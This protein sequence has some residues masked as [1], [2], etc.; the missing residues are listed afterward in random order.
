M[1][2]LKRYI[3]FLL[4]LCSAIGY[5]QTPTLIASGTYKANGSGASGIPTVTINIPAGKNRLMI[6]S[7]FSERIH[8]PYNSNFVTHSDGDTNGDSSHNI[9]VN[10]ISAQWISGPWTDDTVT[11]SKSTTIFSTQNTVRYISDAM[12]MPSGVATITFPGI[13]LPENS[14]DEM[15]VQIAIFENAKPNPTFLK[16]DNARNFNTDTDFLTLSGTTPT[17]P[18][19]NSINNLVFFGTGGISQQNNVLFSS[20]WTTIQTDVMN[21][22][23][24]T[25]S[26]LS[27]M[28]PNEHDGIGYTTAYRTISSGDPSFTL[29]RSATNLSTETA[30]ANLISILPFARPSVS[31]TVY[32]DNNGMTGGIDNGGTGGGTWNIANALYVNAVDT[33]GNVVATALVNTSGVFTF[34]SGGNLIEGDVVKFQLS[35]TQGTVGQPAP[36]KELPAGWAIVGESTTGGSSDGTPNGEFTLTIGTA[37]SPNSTT[38]RFGVVTACNAGASAP[39]VR[40]TITNTCP[41]ITVNLNT[42]QTGTIPAG[43]SLVW[44]TNSNHTGSA[45]SGTQITQAGAGTYYAFYYDSV[46]SCYSPV[47]NAVTVLINTTD[48]DGDGVFDACDLDNDNDGILDTDE[49]FCLSTPLLI[50]SKRFS[51]TGSGTTGRPN[52]TFSA[53]TTG[54]GKRLM[55]LTLTIE[56]DHTPTPYGDNWESTLPATNN[57]TNAPVVKFGSNNMFPSSYNTSLKSSP[58]INHSD[59]TISVTQYVYTLWD[60]QISAGLNSIDLSNFQ[61]PKN[62]GD[63]WHAEILV[64]DN[65]NNYEYIGTK[66]S[67]LAKNDLSISGNMLANSQPAGTIEQNNALL[68]FG[69]TS[70]QSG[71]SINSGWNAITTNS[72]ANTNGTYATDPNT[73]SDLLENDGI[74]V[75]T[76]TKTGVTGNQTATFS[77]N[78]SMSTAIMYR[79]IPFPCNLRDTDGDGIPD[80]LDLDS[81]AD[82]CPDAKEGAGNFN[83]TATASG[84][85]STQTPN[86]NFGTTVDANGVPTAVGASG[87]ALGQSI[88]ASKNDCLDTDG[89]GYP[90][91]QDLDDDNDGILD[92]VENGLNTTIDKIF[93][94]NNNATLIASPSTGPAH[95]YRL[96][97]VGSQ[98]GQI[99]SYG[100]VD[101]TK[102]FSLPMK[103]L[104]SNADG[105][106]IV[107]HNSP[108]A[109][110]ASGTNGQGL[111]ARGIANGIALE[112][113]TFQNGCDNDTNNG[114]NC[115]PDYDHGSIRTTAGW[116]G[117]GKLA[118]DTKLGDGEVH[119]EPWHNVVINWNASTRNLSYTFDGVAV[120]N[121][122]FPTTG[123]NAIETILGGNSAYFG[124]T[125]STGGAGSTNSVGFDDLCALP[126]TLD[127]DNDG[128]S[129]HLDLDSDGD[130][131]A[132]A[133]EGAGNFTASQLTSASGTL[134]S[135]TPNQNFGTTVD[136]NGVPTVVGASGQALGQSQDKTKNDCIDSDGD[137]YPDWVDLDDD[138]DG[139][140]DTDECVL[141]N[142]VTNGNFDTDFT[143]ASDWSN[144]AGWTYNATGK[145]VENTSTFYGGSFGNFTQL[146]SNLP[147]TTIPLTF[148]LGAKDGGGS[149]TG[150][151]EV[152]LGGTLYATVNNSTAT[153][154]NITLTLSNGATSNFTPFTATSTSTYTN[155]TFTINIPYTGP[156]SAALN[157][158]MGANQTDDWSLDNIS[159]NTCDTDA[160]GIPNNLDLDSDNDGCLDA[161]EGG[162]NFTASQLTTASGTIATQT[163]NQNFGIVVDAN[164]VPTIVGATGQTVGQSL[165]ATKNDCLDSDND[166]YPNW[167][168]LDDD[169]D[170]ILDTDECPNVPIISNGTF[171]SPVT[172]WTLGTGW[173]V[174]SGIAINT[175]DNVNSN[176]SQTLNNLNQT[177][178]TVKLSFTLGAQDAFNS[179]SNTASLNIILNGTTYATFNNGSARAIGTNN[180][181]QTLFSGATSTFTPFSTAISPGFTTQNITITI[182][183]TG[184]DSAVLTFNYSASYDDWSIDNV[185]IDTSI[186]DLDGDGISNELDLD[187]DGDGCPDALEGGA[188]ITTNDLVISNLPGGNSGSN[189][190]GT[191]GPVVENL[192]NTV[193]V[194]GVPAIVNGGQSLGDSQNGTINPCCSNPPN[195][196]PATDFTKTGISNLAGFANGWPG[197]VPNGFL[198]IESKNKGFVIT[199]V[200]NTSAIVTPVEGM[201]IYDLSAN[202]VKL[203]NGTSW[204]CLEKDCTGN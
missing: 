10:G 55:F 22:T 107:F 187:S 19:G 195:L 186:C 72:V 130:N 48:L 191:S 9:S 129:N 141:T 37:N 153:T 82:G 103:A 14:G 177:N 87:Q 43:S 109:Q 119:D 25:S 8:D 114:L 104:L 157:F 112:L 68:V 20:G 29:S 159:I 75:F 26:Y 178:G 63:E 118:G 17:I 44:Y 3:I 15:I 115:D 4:V 49:G 172:E 66:A 158:K 175:N 24:G 200:A 67:N 76:A 183:Y 152:F 176:L 167:L 127:S 51:A 150:L 60:S 62:A 38:N 32:I 194:N 11:G 126:L 98:N 50:A 179:G 47:S 146:I 117:T 166:G 79:L 110:S 74:S 173:G 171:T 144:D 136:A 58:S 70:A 131:C 84:T 83:P 113:D 57:F 102:S 155:Q 184:P 61:L 145:Y 1:I 190:T 165:D 27:S 81:D 154:N 143:S 78:N 18:E 201:L 93:K 71:M 122:T 97:N 106:A 168:D 156:K 88:D 125:A 65:V 100:K 124:F 174:S 12:G 101:F 59:A 35:K 188:N 121:Y 203:Y 90:D 193:D 181:T 185:S 120:T 163:P 2:N 41:A 147:P 137:G 42:A 111:G 31:G 108:L 198:A 135:Q 69:A 53:P 123:A 52:I 192:G 161:I 151:L 5:A 89:D 30:S 202:C 23:N 128:I 86:I 204:K 170:G 77:F 96:T 33:K 36:T 138:N 197:N 6:I 13:N 85:L 162:G 56:R 139:I 189:F 21:N 142:L 140:L 105:I 73:S 180:V 64:F 134:T 80:Y 16:W 196:S 39:F 160:D 199:R 28:S 133:I 46:N 94:A 95:Q 164:G 148:T 34:P 169:N 182:P 54:T 132:D 92:C 99:W 45:L 7:T 40:T 91:W 116:V 149:G